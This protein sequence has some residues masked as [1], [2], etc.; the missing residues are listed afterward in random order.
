MRIPGRKRNNRPTV[1][2][3]TNYRKKYCEY[4][5]NLHIILIYFKSAFDT[6]NRRA[7]IQTMHNLGISKKI[8]RLTEITLKDTKCK[9]KIENDISATFQYNEGVNQGDGWSTELFNILLHRIIK[10]TDKRGTVF[11]KLSQIC[12]YVDDVTITAKTEKERK[13]V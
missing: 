9:V 12:A 13:R 3:E 6:V 10:T 2:S 8:I 1:Y 11:T 7:L 5:I 4:N